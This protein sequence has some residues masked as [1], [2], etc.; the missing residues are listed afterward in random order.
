MLCN[1]RVV[2]VCSRL[3]RTC[4]PITCR[5]RALEGVTHFPKEG[6]SLCDRGS[7][8]RIPSCELLNKK[9][10]VVPFFFHNSV[11][12]L[13]SFSFLLSLIG[14]IHQQNTLSYSIMGVLS[15]GSLSNDRLA[16]LKLYKY[17]AVDKS[18]ISRYVLKHYWNWS[19]ELFPLWI[20]QVSTCHLL[21]K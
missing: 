11:F 9:S 21:E 16:N 6:C 17:S 8:L 2:C 19:I 10:V 12:P 20:A 3:V 18:F 1:T 5:W 15:S 13:F 4:N 7:D 14:R